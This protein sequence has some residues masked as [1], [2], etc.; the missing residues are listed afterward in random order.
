[1]Y[2][3]KFKQLAGSG[4]LVIASL[5]SVQAQASKDVTFA[6]ALTLETLD[7]YN[8]NSTLNQ[9]AG[10]A[11][12]EGLYEF[13]KDLK[14][15]PKLATEYSVTP[16]GLVYTL[17]LRS[18]VKFHD[19]TDFTA[20]AVKANLDRVSNPENKLAR[21]TQF[22]R[23]KKTD[24]IDSQTVQITLTEPFSAFINAL[25]HPAAMMISPTAL[26]KYG[27]DIGFHPVG[28]GPFQFVDWK[29]A[30]YLKVEKFPGYWN[31]GFPKIDTLTFRTVSDNNTRAA[32]VQTGEA[33]FAFPIPYEQIAVLQKNDKLDIVDDKQ[34]IMARYMSMNVREKPFNDVKVR[35]AINYAI[36]KEALSKVAYSGFATPLDGVIPQGVEY[37]S[38]SGPWPYDVKKAKALLAEA[39]YPNGFETTLWSAYNDG[40]SVKVV[41]FLQQQLSQ[42]GIKTSIEILES[43]QRV[44]RVNQVQKPEDAKVR[45]YYAGWSSST[46]E[47]DWAIRPLLST[48]AAPPVMNNTAYYSNPTV[49]A[50]IMR[51]LTTTDSTEKAKLYKN[52][53]DTVW[54]DAPWA[55]L[56]TANNVYVRSKALSGVYVQPDTSFWFGDIDL[57]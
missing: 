32:V 14:I 35:Q 26:T 47:A 17:K 25:A 18:G 49:D 27:K 48:A 36:N 1:M 29:P 28:T 38:K 3:N 13:D 39:G 41:Q 51:A 22:N 53:Q 37:A 52:A 24:V 57:K 9:A 23:V 45:L 44:A 20:E 6:V 10:K 7:P 31:K 21:Y 16:D 46:G 12:Y 15:R 43:G 19:G 55:F 56:V 40:T 8:T 30:E 50:D 33:Q 11:Y 54:K 34:S 42:V 5:C 2:K 4:L